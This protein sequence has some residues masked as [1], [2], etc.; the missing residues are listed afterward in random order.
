MHHVLTKSTLFII[1]Y[2]ALVLGVL[3][4]GIFFAI[5]GMGI[6]NVGLAIILFTVVIYVAMT[7][8]QVKQ[9][10]FSKLNALMQPEIQ[11]IQAKYK[12]K[13]DQVSQQRMMDET[14]AVYRKYG[15]SATG[16]CVQLL[17]QMPILF[18]LY[19]VIYK[20]PGYI[21]LIGDKLGEAV[22]TSGVTNFINTYVTDLGNRTLTA[23]LTDAPTSETYIDVLYKLNTSQWS[24]VLTKA[25]GESFEPILQST[26]EYVSKV[27]NFLGLNIS[28]TP[29]NLFTTGW[30][31]K[32]FL[33]MFAA[34]LF[35]ILA[36]V[37][38]RLNFKMNPTPENNNKNSES[39][40]MNNTLNS[41]NKTMP[42]VSA[43]F[44]FT[45]PVGIGIYWIIGA[46]IRTLQMW[47]INKK[48]DK[49]DINEIIKANQEKM[50]KEAEKKGV[51]NAQISRNTSINTRN[52]ETAA[53][54]SKQAQIEERLKALEER[55]SIQA[56]PG[57]LASKANMVADYEAKHGRTRKH[58]DAK[59]K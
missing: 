1:K 20:I 22:N 32:T 56:E 41:M 8:L 13:K 7:P 16:S 23:T 27:T 10:R 59:K 49:E 58:A 28:D 11:K 53:K 18:G 36:Y 2:V 15:V 34:V 6:P 9:Q 39:N 44:C 37:T 25:Q 47:L 43:V 19:Q 33:L 38:Q 50:A 52:I 40:Q 35:P 42:L 48:I 29:M 3:M 31:N 26:H 30:S 21:T 14:Q 12:N 4:N 24:D 57:S 46:L 45:L 5:N 55:E 51:T 17:V 54:T